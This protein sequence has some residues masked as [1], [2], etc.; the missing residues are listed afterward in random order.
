MSNWWI[1]V[2]CLA[3][4]LSSNSAPALKTLLKRHGKNYLLKNSLIPCTKL[5][6][7]T[8]HDYLKD[9]GGV[10][11]GLLVQ[12]QITVFHS[13]INQAEKFGNMT[14]ASA[15]ELVALE[16]VG[17]N[18]KFTWIIPSLIRFLCQQFRQRVHDIPLDE[19]QQHDSYLI[20]WLRGEKSSLVYK[21]CGEWH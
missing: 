19:C 17:Y 9:S 7:Y 13:S 3:P 15:K 18:V 14:Q 1:A 11:C 5:T 21:M 12:S 16:K 8:W 20:R 4:S 10:P 2:V 6:T